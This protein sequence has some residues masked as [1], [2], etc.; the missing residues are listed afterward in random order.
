MEFLKPLAVAF[1]SLGL[2]VSSWFGLVPETKVLILENQLRNLT[3]KV[4]AVEDT[5]VFGAY[6]TS[7]GGSYRLKSSLSSTDATINLSSFKEPVSNIPYSMAFLNTSIGYGTVEPLTSD[8]SEFISFSGITQNADGSAQ[9]TGVVRGLTKSP[10][11]LAC[12]ASTT[13]AARHPAQSIFILSDSPCHLA[14][15]AVKRN[16]ES[17]S[18]SWAFPYPT[19]SSS[20][21]TWGSVTDVI[22]T[23]TINTDSLIIAAIAG[24]T[25]TSGQIV[26]LNRYDREW[27]KA[28]AAIGSTTNDVQLGVAQGAGTDGNSIS[29]GVL[30]HGIDY[31]NSHSGSAT[32]VYLSNTAGATSTTAGSIQKVL[33]ISKSTGVSGLYFDPKSA[34]NPFSTSTFAGGITM[35]GNA[36]STF[37]STSIKVYLGTAGSSATSTW[38]VPSNLKYIIVEMVGGG[39]G[40]GGTTNTWQASGGGGAGAYCRK[41]YSAAEIGS[42]SKTVVAGRGGAAG[43]AT[44][45]DGG[46]GGTSTFG[47]TATTTGGAGG[48]GATTGGNGGEGG[49]ASGCDINANGGEGTSGFTTGATAIITGSGG[50]SFF[51]GGAFGPYAGVATS[52]QDGEAPGSGGSGGGNASGS[53]DIPGGAGAVGMVVITEVTY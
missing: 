52:G 50:A 1:T 18:G 20:P 45:G 9:L 39:G 31:K 16:D 43:A 8:K 41:I 40:G 25:I 10:A 26:Y 22:T 51:G 47:G 34:L 35:T 2:T 17:I 33:G 48:L 15:Y 5:V 14:E 44:G 11:G 3:S 32:T 42:S 13:L 24:E 4:E 27:Y 23:G 38:T 30:L 29:G 19:A 46:V 49:E 12:T 53:G 37:A 21:A 6:N 36:T 7:G 28:S